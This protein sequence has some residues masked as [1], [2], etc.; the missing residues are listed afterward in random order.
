MVLKVNNGMSEDNLIERAKIEGVQVYGISSY[1]YD[2]PPARYHDVV[3]LGF[4]ALEETEI[5]SAITLLRK[6]WFD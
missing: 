5:V 6:A 1:F 2:T 3:A 4:A